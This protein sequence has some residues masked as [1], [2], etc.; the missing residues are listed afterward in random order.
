MNDS[1]NVT[2]LLHSLEYIEKTSSK[3][4]N[5]ITASEHKKR[6]R[7]IHIYKTLHDIATLYNKFSS[8]QAKDISEITIVTNALTTF[9]ESMMELTSEA[10]AI[11]NSLADNRFDTMK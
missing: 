10:F 8:Y 4:I 5:I 11:S 2:S 6:L 9:R 1:K 3:Q 7:L